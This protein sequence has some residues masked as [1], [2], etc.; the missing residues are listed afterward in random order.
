MKPQAAGRCQ[1]GAGGE[2]CLVVIGEVVKSAR[3][4]THAQPM[5]VWPMLVFQLF[6]D[7][8]FWAYEDG[9]GMPDMLADRI[10]VCVELFV[11]VHR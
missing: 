3:C 11:R 6:F 1:P 2:A 7:F 5:C 8:M 9:S 4:F 10:L